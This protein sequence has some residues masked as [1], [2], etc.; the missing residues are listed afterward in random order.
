MRRR[1]Q[2]PLPK[3]HGL[4]PAR[5][6]LPED[7]DWATIRDHLVD[8]LPRVRPERIDE[9]LREGGIVDLDGPIAL[10]TPY[11]PGGAVWFHRDLPEETEVPFPIG[12]VHRDDDILVVDKPHFL[13]TI[14]RGQHILQTALVKLR[15]ELDLP[16]LVPAHRLDRVTAGLVLFIVNPAR[17][18]AYQTMFHKRLV[19]KEYQAIARF[20]PELALPRTVISRIV[21]ERQVL[22]AYETE[23]EPN[24][25]TVVELLDHR[26]GMGRYLLKPRTGRTHQLRLH[27]NGLG[28]PILG[29]DFYPE[30]TDKP[31]DD[32]TRPL[33]LLASTLEFTDPITKEPRR[34]ETARTLQAWDDPE[35][36]ALG[37]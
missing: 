7:G 33:Q 32:Y 9:L 15:R 26:D 29:D 24:A 35:G 16:D 12:I 1:Q 5:L 23:G 34:F 2:P 25:E 4:D 30:L 27:M 19:R 8:R 31:V 14:P 18:G 17:R 13:S 22:R 21:K 37:R 20:D 3:R 11:A 36:W 10:D 28:I 6:R